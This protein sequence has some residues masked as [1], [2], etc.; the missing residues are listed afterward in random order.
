MAQVYGVYDFRALSPVTAAALATG[1]PDDSRV[2]RFRSGEKYS[3]DQRVMM[4][5]YDRVN[6]LMWSKTK[7]AQKGGDPPLP[8]EQLI[9][10]TAAQQEEQ[11]LMG[12]DSPEELMDYLYKRGGKSG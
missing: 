10:Q 6:W 8:L 9:E 7:A 12:F 5:I 2:K 3:F 11:K 4:L 1:L